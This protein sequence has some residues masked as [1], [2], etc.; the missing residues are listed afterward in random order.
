MFRQFNFKAFSSLIRIAI[1]LQLI[2]WCQ[3]DIDGKNQTF[4]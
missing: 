2:D 4:W 1:E 3:C